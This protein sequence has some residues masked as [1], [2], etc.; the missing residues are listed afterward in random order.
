[1]ASCVNLRDMRAVRVQ[2]GL[3]RKRAAEKRKTR[4]EDERMLRSGKKNRRQLRLENGLFS[5]VKVRLVLEKAK[6]L[7]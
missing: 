7:C 5:G 6:A 4:E 3:F 2:K 1:M